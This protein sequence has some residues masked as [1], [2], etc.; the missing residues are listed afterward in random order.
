MF[1]IFFHVQ[2]RYQSFHEAPPFSCYSLP[3][4]HTRSI[5]SISSCFYFAF[6][7]HE[8][9][10]QKVSSQSFISHS[11]NLPCIFTSHAYIWLKGSQFLLIHINLQ[12]LSI[13]FFNLF[14]SL[15]YSSLAWQS[16]NNYSLL[17]LSYSSWG[18]PGQYLG[19]SSLLVVC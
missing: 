10:S 14:T 7:P 15:L 2:K 19:P 18:S 1:P 5:L 12:H 13:H 11:T 4:H 6:A 3:A 17:I 8:L 9:F 16:Y